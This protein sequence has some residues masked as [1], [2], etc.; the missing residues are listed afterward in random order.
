MGKATLVTP[1]YLSFAWT[2]MISYQLFTQTAVM[3]VV[4]FANVLNP[5]IGEWLV[6]R[7]DMLVFVYAFAWVFVLSSVIPSLILGKER[8]VLA[9]FLVCLALTFAAFIIQDL[10]KNYENSAFNYML[11]L[12]AFFHNPIVAGLYLMAPYFFMLAID[13]HCRRANGR[14]KKIQEL[15]A[16]YLENT[17]LATQEEASSN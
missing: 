8:S 6:L 2:L 7:I 3:T 17:A 13:I 9:Q 5:A 1:L 15:T 12:N 4:S 16:M 14:K 11:S 10:M